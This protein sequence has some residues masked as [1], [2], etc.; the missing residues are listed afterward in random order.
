MMFGMGLVLFS[1]G[2]FFSTIV[3]FVQARQMI[4]GEGTEA[5]AMQVGGSSDG[6]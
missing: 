6:E 4:I 3:G 2:R 5:I 1:I